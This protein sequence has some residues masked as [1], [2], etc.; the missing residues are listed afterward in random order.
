MTTKLP[1][2]AS[3]VLLTEHCR[4][5][6]K[7]TMRSSGLPHQKGLTISF[8]V[9]PNLPEDACL[10]KTSLLVQCHPSKYH[11]SPFT[12]PSLIPFKATV[13]GLI[14]NDFRNITCRP[15]TNPNPML[16]G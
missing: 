8:K 5:D 14:S 4:K 11:R 12:C 16:N 13:Y 3:K 6:S 9:E 15:Q 1:C 2:N 7:E 10:N